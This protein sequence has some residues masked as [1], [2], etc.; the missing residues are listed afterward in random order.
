MNFYKGFR[1]VVKNR[2][3]SLKVVYFI[4]DFGGSQ[5]NRYFLHNSTLPKAMQEFDDIGI[6]VMEPGFTI[7]IEKLC[8]LMS[9]KARMQIKLQP[10]NLTRKIW[11]RQTRLHQLLQSTLTYPWSG[12]REHIN[13]E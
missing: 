4:S 6:P 3:S 13:M 1:D 2:N 8:L 9:S 11:A 12:C 7:W 5:G 10:L